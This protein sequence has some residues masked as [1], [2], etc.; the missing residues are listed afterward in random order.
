ME[1][2]NTQNSKWI[3]YISREKVLFFLDLLFHFFR[4]KLSREWRWKKIKSAKTLTDAQL[5]GYCRSRTRHKSGPKQWQ[6]RCA[7]LLMPK[8]RLDYTREYFLL[9]RQMIMNPVCLPSPFLRNTF[10]NRLRGG[11]GEAKMKGIVAHAPQ[12]VASKSN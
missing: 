11:G 12:H 2:P 8:L 1:K 6:V 9:L 4:Y 5:I 7:R 10:W 3:I